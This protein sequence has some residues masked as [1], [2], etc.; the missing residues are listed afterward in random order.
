MSAEKLS[1]YL[2]G[3][4][5]VALCLWA[6]TTPPNPVPAPISLFILYITYNPVVSTSLFKSE[7]VT[8]FGIS[9]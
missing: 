4:Q 5:W 7:G 6:K 1:E 3:K 2:E 8:A 9:F